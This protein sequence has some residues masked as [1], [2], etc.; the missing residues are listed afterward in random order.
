MQPFAVQ[1]FKSS[2]VQRR[3]KAKSKIVFNEFH[4]MSHDSIDA[5]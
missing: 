1:Q 5:I 4:A 3:K 2:T